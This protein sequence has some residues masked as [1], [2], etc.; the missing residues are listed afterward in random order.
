M[1]Q[2]ETTTPHYK[3]QKVGDSF[4][5]VK[6]SSPASD[7]EAAMWCAAGG[8]LALYG[9]VR[10][11]FLGPVISVAGGMMIYRGLTGRNPLARVLCGQNQAPSG[12]ASLAPSYQHDDRGPAATQQP[13][14]E[15]DEA[16]MESFPA[17]DP[18][19]RTATV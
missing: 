16:A 5:P 3:V 7:S 18:P 19:S 11:G 6:Q 15:I 2:Q 10:R 13:A 12:D 14:D 17:S 4:V 9:L 8:V 1:T